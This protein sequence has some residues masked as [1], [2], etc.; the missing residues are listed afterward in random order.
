MVF[1]KRLSIKS[2]KEARIVPRNT[3]PGNAAAP[4]TRHYFRT[5]I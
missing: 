3:A 2:S 1:F 4:A 5:V